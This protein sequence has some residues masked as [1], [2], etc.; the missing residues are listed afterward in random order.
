MGEYMREFFGDL[1][2]ILLIVV[3]VLAVI[4]FRDTFIRLLSRNKVVVPANFPETQVVI[5]PEPLRRTILLGALLFVPQGTKAVVA[6]HPTGNPVSF[7]EGEHV[8]HFHTIYALVQ[9]VDM[10]RRA[11]T[12]SV[13]MAS[14]RDGFLIS[15]RGKISWKVKNE[16][17]VAAIRDPFTEILIGV[18][19]AV[20]STTIDYDHDQLVTT[21]GNQPVSDSELIEKISRKLN[22]TK[23]FE[24]IDLQAIVLDSRIGDPQRT[25]I[26]K[27][28]V[29]QKINTRLKREKLG[30]RIELAEMETAVA[31]LEGQIEQERARVENETRLQKAE[32]TVREEAILRPVREEAVVLEHRRD[33][34]RLELEREKVYVQARTAALEPITKIFAHLIGDPV[35]NG[36]SNNGSIDRLN[37]VLEFI[38]G[39]LWHDPSILTATHSHGLPPPKNAKEELFSQLNETSSLE[40]FLGQNLLELP[41]GRWNLRILIKDNRLEFLYNLANYRPKIIGIYMVNSKDFV[42]TKIDPTP[43]A[44]LKL[45]Q[46]IRKLLE[47]YD[48]D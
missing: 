41:D 23:L 12:F 35:S 44:S 14:S 21:P 7:Q 19:N 9:Y 39:S 37:R 40:G 6:L 13:E 26:A 11:N 4:R 18:E 15:L 30:K 2:F 34:P 45:P 3:V 20:R 33:R 42:Y 16:I 25:E 10:R 43:Y 24:L 29:L 17:A 1:L 5:T 22:N 46:V 32:I 8:I 48:P 27:E 36:M 28:T 47:K 31:V 38:V